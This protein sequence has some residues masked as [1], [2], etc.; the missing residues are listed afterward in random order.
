MSS[1]KPGDG[2]RERNGT[3]EVGDTFVVANGEGTK[4]LESRKKILDPVPCSVEVLIVVTRGC[5][6]GFG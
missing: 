5:P 2:G 1:I 3:E 4:L 6:V